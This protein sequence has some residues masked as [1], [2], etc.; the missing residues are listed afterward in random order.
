LGR[1]G[2]SAERRHLLSAAEEE[3]TLDRINRMNG[4]FLTTKH[5]KL[6]TE[7]CGELAAA[8]LALG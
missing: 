3:L 7:D 8:P 1:S 4:I 5:T 2:V 6:F